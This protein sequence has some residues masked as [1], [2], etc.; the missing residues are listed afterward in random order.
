[1]RYNDTSEEFHPQHCL[2]RKGK[3]ERE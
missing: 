3:K 1:M 2:S